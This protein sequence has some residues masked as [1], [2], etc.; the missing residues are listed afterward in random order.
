MPQ[1]TCSPGQKKTLYPRP[2]P[3]QDQGDMKSIIAP[4]DIQSLSRQNQIRFAVR[5]GRHK[6]SPPS[7]A[8]PDR[9]P[10]APGP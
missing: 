6:S 5:D 4:Q 7:I 1:T 3:G 2:L 10:A 8:D 9:F